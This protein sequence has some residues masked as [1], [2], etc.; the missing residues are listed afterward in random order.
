[1]ETL[2]EATAP[3]GSAALAPEPA[4]LVQLLFGK[5]ITFGISALA[6]LGVPD[7]MSQ[8]KPITS[9]ALAAKVGAHQPSLYRLM[10]ML[11]CVGVFEEPTPGSFVLTPVG[12]LLKTDAP[13]S[14]RHFA[15]QFGDKWSTRAMEHLTDTIR[16]GIDSV[17]LAF[18]RNVFDYFATEPEQAETFN[19]SMSNLSAALIRPIVDN[20]DFSSIQ[21]LAD[22]GGGHGMLLSAILERNPAMRGVVFDLPNVVSGAA[23]QPHLA[24]VA[25]RIDFEGGSFSNR[26]HRSV[27]RTF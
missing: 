25:E 22:I 3:A 1:M 6:R 8:T 27:T 5:H 11:T 19:R 12:E 10:R 21:R 16:T 14:M 9:A 26:R 13:G 24:N 7:H 18:G 23:G 4:A 2:L 15:I 17:T 20:Y